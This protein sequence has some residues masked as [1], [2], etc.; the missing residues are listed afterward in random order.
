MPNR[1]KSQADT[2]SGGWYDQ[3][4]SVSYSRESEGGKR[5]QALIDGG[6]PYDPSDP[7]EPRPPMPDFGQDIPDNFPFLLVQMV[8]DLRTYLALSAANSAQAINFVPA[9]KTSIRVVLYLVRRQLG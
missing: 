9:L 4:D 3:Q 6:E 2:P 8:Q 7:P 5:I 1:Y